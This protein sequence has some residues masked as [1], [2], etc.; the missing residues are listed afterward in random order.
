MFSTNS[1]HW[2]ITWPL[3]SLIGIISLPCY[4]QTSEEFR[5]SDFYAGNSIMRLTGQSSTEEMTLPLSPTVKVDAA[6]LKLQIT[7]SIVLSPDRSVLNVRFNN[8]TIGQIPFDPARPVISSEIPIPISLWRPGYNSLSFV[9]TQSISACEKSSAP[10]LWSEINLYQSSLTIKTRKNIEH[11]GLQSLSGFFHPGIGSQNKARIFTG[12]EGPEQAMIMA[13][14]LPL[15]AQGLALRKQYR[16]LA[17]RHHFLPVPDEQSTLAQQLKSKQL[18]QTYQHSAWYLTQ[19]NNNSPREDALHVLVGT[20]KALRRF[21]TTEQQQNIRGPYLGIEKTPAVRLNQQELIPA[22]YRLIVAGLDERQVMQAALALGYMDDP[23]NPDRQ[24][25][26]L[27]DKSL[28]PYL[29]QQTVTLHPGQTYS[30]GDLG[31]DSFSFTGGG[32]FTKPV[33]IRLPADFYVTEDASVRLSLN[34]GYGAGFGPGSVMNLLANQQIVYGLALDNLNGESFRHYVLRIPARYFRGGNNTLT[35]VINQNP[36]PADIECADISGNYL[37]FQVNRTSQI[38]LPQASHLARQPDLRLLAQT[39][40]PLT[41][42]TQT[43]PTGIYIAQPAMMSAALT[44]AGKLAQSSHNLI[45]ALQVIRGI[46][47][48][49]PPSA[50]LLARP[51]D[52]NESLFARVNTAIT[53]TKQWPYRLQNLLLNQVRDKDDPVRLKPSTPGGYTTQTGT[54]G[55]MAILIATQNPLSP[56]SGTLFVMTAENSRMLTERVNQLVQ[57]SLWGQLTGDFFAW[58]TPQAPLLVMQV[59]KTFE[60]GHA[61]LWLTLRAWSSN[62]PWYWII[63]AV[64][65]VLLISAIA[66]RLLKRRHRKLKEQ[67]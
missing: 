56:Q 28:M 16:P 49:L 2:M 45:P 40:Y 55:R 18:W 4:A 54:L 65:T 11:L 59:A 53:Q 63:V 23:L 17:F 25:N 15:I 3:C 31:T 66:Y 26:I 1:F 42:F 34:F 24:I 36:V 27:A 41:E 5:L 9:A 10:E 21:L 48:Q 43:Q 32:E 12:G 61:S 47:E 35:F 22:R 19:D 7:S 51:V 60:V 57:N 13:Q 39:G 37:R 44:I 8:A 38:I 29:P 20:S 46:P 6:V 58:Q 14:A 50:I 52:L 30:F 62:H 67:W 64:V 33:N